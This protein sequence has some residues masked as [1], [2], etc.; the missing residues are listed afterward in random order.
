MPH[1][2][3]DMVTVLVFRRVAGR[4]E[5][6]QLR[7]AKDPARGTWQPIMGGVTPGEKASAAAVRELQEETG[8]D[9]AS[10]ACLGLWALDQVAPFFMQTL[11]AVILSPVFAAEAAPAWSPALNPENDSSRWV[12]AADIAEAFIW[13]GHVASCREVLDWL[14]RPGSACEPL[15]RV[16]RA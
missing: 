10:P 4:V 16:P 2:R 9:A 5:F 8:L 11:D 14:L 12:P 3:A 6:L 7:R 1:I 13:P 15:L